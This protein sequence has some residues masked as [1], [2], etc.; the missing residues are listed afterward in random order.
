MVGSRGRAADRT[1]WTAGRP[2]Q[3]TSRPPTAETGA[4]QQQ[5][6][7]QLHINA[8]VFLAFPQFQ[9]KCQQPLATE[10]VVLCE[11][12]LVATAAGCSVLTAGSSVT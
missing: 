8:D 11:N 7:Q 4:G 12:E 9:V 3:D 5:K 2:G 1:G 10:I 6:K